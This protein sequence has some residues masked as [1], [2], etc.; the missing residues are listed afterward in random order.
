MGRGHREGGPR[1]PGQRRRPGRP[2]PPLGRG[3][4]KGSDRVRP[5]RRAHR[6]RRQ[7][8]QAGTGARRCAPSPSAPPCCSCALPHRWSWT[9][10]PGPRGATPRSCKPSGK[11]SRPPAHESPHRAEVRKP[12]PGSAWSLDRLAHRA[13]YLSWSCRPDEARRQRWLDEWHERYRCE[14]SCVV[15]GRVL[16]ARRRRPP[17]RQL[18]TPGGGRLF[19]SVPAC[20]R[21]D[22]ALHFVWDASPTWRAMGREAASAG[23]AVGPAPLAGR[24]EAM[25]EREEEAATRAAIEELLASA[26]VPG[27]GA[28]LAAPLHWPELPAERWAEEIGSLRAWVRRLV[29]RFDLDAHVVPACWWRHNHLVEVLGALRDYGGLLRAGVPGHGRGRVPPGA[30]RHGGGTSH[31]GGRPALRGRPRPV[32]RQGRRLPAEGWERWVDGEAGRR[33]GRAASSA[34]DAT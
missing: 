7:P 17:P 4:G 21:C 19:R 23:I 18:C 9:S 3:G 26:G 1:G 2:L 14:P 34:A 33:Q 29:E 8:P 5:R 27:L 22:E 32:P 24:R 25:A 13:E 20:R 16:E 11:A 28:G 30:A 31:L 10:S 12:R 15:C 6:H